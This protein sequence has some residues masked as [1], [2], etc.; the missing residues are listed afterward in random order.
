[1]TLDTRG[2][3]AA[4][5]IHRAVEVMEMSTFTKGP[6]KLE[7]FD[8]FRDRKQR[9]RRIGAIVVG[10][11]IAITTVVVVS[12]NA[13]DRGQGTVP[14]DRGGNPQLTPVV[15]PTQ[16]GTVTSSGGGCTLEIEAET[17]RAG[18]GSLTVVNE[19]NRPVSFQ[20]VRLDEDVFTFE[21]FDVALTEREVGPGA[22]GTIVDNFSSGDTYEVVCAHRHGTNLFGPAWKAFAS[23]G[24]IAV[25]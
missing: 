3:R 16:L 13:L 14:A 1:M 18:A 17:I 7:R 8:R 19:T 23:V 24:P 9:N 25:P 10:T 4:Q 5:G 21:E 12:T 2:R 15:E 22:S 11:A 6:R 20:L